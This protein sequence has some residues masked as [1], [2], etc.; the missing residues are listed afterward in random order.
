MP[1]AP[2]V[3]ASYSPGRRGR[4]VSVNVSSSRRTS[5]SIVSPARSA[6]AAMRADESR[7]VS[8]S[9]CR[10]MSPTRSPPSAAGEPGLTLAI[11]AE[12]VKRMASQKKRMADRKLAP[13][14][15]ASTNSR[16]R[17]GAELSP[18]G[19]SGSSSPAGRTKPPTG[20]QLME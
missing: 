9:T 8:P 10:T 17:L 20:I 11:W 2:S 18:P 3:A 14:P 1:S 7:T 5:K 15:A 13:A 12:G 16:T 19:T 6:T 4:T